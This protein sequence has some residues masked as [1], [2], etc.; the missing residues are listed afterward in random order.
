MSSHLTDSEVYG[1]LWTT[2]ELHA[3]FD[4]RGRTSAWLTIL[5]AL[6]QAQAEVGL[7]PAE[8]AALIEEHATIDRLDL[9]VVA[10]GTRSSG[11]STHGLIAHLR[12]IL[13]Q[14]SVERELMLV[15]I[16]PPEEGHAE[17]RALAETY[18]A[19]IVDVSTEA[20]MVEATGTTERLDALEKRLEGYGI[21]ELSR[22]GRIALE[23]GGKSLTLR[24]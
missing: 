15:K 16:K 21:L 3:L 2:P 19:R 23:R 14:D 4:D 17:L 22:T 24:T 10:E 18:G 6:A 20:L 7:V 5:A 13:P 11:H 12:E 1:H 9:A 8:A